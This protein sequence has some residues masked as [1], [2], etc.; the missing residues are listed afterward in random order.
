MSSDFSALVD[1][2]GQASGAIERGDSAV[3]K[4]VDKLEDCVNELYRKTSPRLRHQRQ[5]RRQLRAQI[6]GRDVSYPARAQ[7]PKDRRR[8]SAS[9]TS[10]L[11]KSIWSMAYSAR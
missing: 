7:G 9:S 3:N 5:R 4:R 2:I 1:E 10:I 11:R 8:C 6:R